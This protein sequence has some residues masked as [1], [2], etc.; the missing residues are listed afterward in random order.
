MRWC[1]CLIVPG[2]PRKPTAQLKL[3][4]SWRAKE[5]ERTEPK[6]DVAR[7]ERP[8]WLDAEGCAAWDRLCPLLERMRVLTVADQ[9]ALAVLC[10]TWSRYRRVCAKLAETGE[11]Y[12]VL[13]EDGRLKMLRRSPYSVLQ[14]ELARSLRHMLA[15]FGLTPAARGRV[16][17]LPGLESDGKSSLFTRKSA[18][19]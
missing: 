17:T 19:A 1:R 6:L 2:P 12:E 8:D 9:T 10:E 5:R 3:V 15:E 16:V 4:G 11:V 7:P 18:S 14:M 13:E